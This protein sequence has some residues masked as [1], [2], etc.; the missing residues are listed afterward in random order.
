LS[1]MDCFRVIAWLTLGAVPLLLLIQR[2]KPAGKSPA[3]H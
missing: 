2:F 3:A 1:F